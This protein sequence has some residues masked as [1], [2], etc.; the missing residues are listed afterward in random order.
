MST[1]IRPPLRTRPQPAL[2]TQ[3]GIALLEALLAIVILGIGLL[4]AVGMQARAV[5]ALSDA[6]QR[7][8]ATLAADR[9][10]GI[11][12][13]DGASPF[14]YVTAPGAAPS[15]SLSPWHAETRAAIPGAT[16]GVA[17]E[18]AGGN[19]NRVDVSIAWTRKAGDRANTHR[20][21]FYMAPR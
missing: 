14:N 9:L 12:H 21:S 5:S 3:R 2:R 17:V 8:E 20:V 18:A 13:A 6:G 10:A 4:G 16:I 11:M 1:M 15:T 7:A 19:G